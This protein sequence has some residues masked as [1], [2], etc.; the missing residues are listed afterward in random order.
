MFLIEKIDRLILLTI[1]GELKDGEVNSIKSKLKEL[2][3]TNDEIVLSID[4]S[5]VNKKS[6]NYIEESKINEILEFCHVSGI[7]V[8]FY[9]FS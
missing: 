6:V 3:K 7:R 2:I 4:L 5:Y 9:R 8:H 1:E